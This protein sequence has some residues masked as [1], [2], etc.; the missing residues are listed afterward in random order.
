MRMVI[1]NNNSMGWK[2]DFRILDAEKWARVRER[3]EG[4]GGGGGAEENRR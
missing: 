4:G 3:C 2:D 1:H